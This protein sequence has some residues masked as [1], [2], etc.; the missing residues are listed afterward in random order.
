MNYTDLCAAAG[1][2]P[3]SAVVIGVKGTIDP[4]GTGLTYLKSVGVVC[5][6]L[7]ISGTGPFQ[8]TTTLTEAKIPRG[9][10]PGTVPQ[11]GMCPANEVVVGFDSRAAMYID[12]L[13]FR[14]APLTVVPGPQGYALSIGTS[15]ATSAV[16]ADGG[17]L[18]STVVCPKDSVAV[19]SILRAGNAI[20]A[21]G[22]GCAPVSLAFAP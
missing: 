7:A 11:E 1:G 4:P 17:N 19:G 20:D 16:G 3:G 5:G 10:L 14:C 21:F 6:T 18:Q 8:V 15:K 13:T 9:N 12:Q 2:S 22:F